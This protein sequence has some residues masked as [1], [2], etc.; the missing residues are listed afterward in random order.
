MCRHVPKVPYDSF[1]PGSRHL[2]VTE[3]VRLTVNK[4][5]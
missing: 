5:S 2:D 1:A 3:V 4:L